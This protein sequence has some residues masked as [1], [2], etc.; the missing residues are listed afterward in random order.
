[1]AAHLSGL[2]RNFTDVFLALLFALF[3]VL[4]CVGGSSRIDVAG[5]PLVLATAWLIMIIVILSAPRPSTENRNPMM[6]LAAIALVPLV[7]LVPLPPTLWQMLPGHE[8]MTEAS[9]M[10]GEAQPWRPIAVAPGVTLNAF[11][12]LIVPATVLMLASAL[13]EKSRAW[14]L[15]MIIALATA[16]AIVALIQFSGNRFQQAMIGYRAD[17]SGN[18]GNRN[19][20]G[21][22]LSCAC[23]AL[24]IWALSKPSGLGW[25]VPVALCLSVLFV[26]TVLASGSRAGLAAAGVALVMGPLAVREQIRS[27]LS[28]RPRWVIPAIGIGALSVVSLATAVSFKLGRADSI[29]RLIG[30]D[31][32]DDMRS[33]ALPTVIKITKDYFPFGIGVGGFDPVFR[34]YEPFA[35]LKP[36]YFNQAHND[37]LSTLLEGGLLG[38]CVL[39]AAIL[40]WGRASLSVWRTVD[41]NDGGRNTIMLGRFGSGT[42]GLALGASLVD[43]PG[44]APLSAATFALAAAMLAWAEAKRRQKSLPPVERPI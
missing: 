7:Q 44:R 8:W 42:L 16:A 2:Q 29:N 15:G 17:I 12:S 36:T 19:H 34:R 11:F 24:P 27:Q 18:F 1:M 20:F 37:I 6:V 13:K 39:L 25:R 10:S 41:R 28:T 14:L 33:R 21:L 23:L 26:L 32:G 5:Q 30:G 38:L 3:A 40:W 43:Y 9:Q 4:W 31:L 22:F 35:L